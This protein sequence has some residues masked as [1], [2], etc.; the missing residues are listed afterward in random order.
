MKRFFVLTL[1][2]LCSPVFADFVTIDEFTDST[3]SDGL[4]TRTTSG[5]VSFNELGIELG[6]VSAV[7]G[8]PIVGEAS[9]TYAF[10]PTPINVVPIFILKA[11]NNQ[12]DINELGQLQVS[13]NGNTPISYLLPGKQT[14]YVSYSF[15]F[16]HQFTVPSAALIDELKI[17]W[18]RPQGYTGVAQLLL[19][20]IEAHNVPEPST[21][22][23][24]S[25]V[26]S[27][28]TLYRWRRKARCLHTSQLQG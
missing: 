13:V 11:R 14:D 22:V 18:F 7:S 5:L 17:S 6:T 1:A 19:T 21:I 9:I 10:T 23:L 3:Q 27:V 25:F 20:S 8:V 28:S 24:L 2:T 26:S 16:T 4:G 12:T 15:D